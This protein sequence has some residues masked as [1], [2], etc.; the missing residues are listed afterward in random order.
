MAKELADAGLKVVA[1]ERGRMIDPQH[2]FA[3]PST[4]D[5]LKFDRHSDIFQDL[6]R[7]TLTFRNELEREGAADARD[8]LV[9]AGG[10]RGRHGA[11]LEHPRAPLPAVGLRDPQPHHRALRQ[12]HDPRKLHE[13]GLGRH[14]RRAGAVLRPVRA[15]LRRRRQGRQPA[16]RDPGGRQSV[17]GSALARVPEPAVAHDLRGDDVRQGLRGAGLQGPRESDCGADTGLHEPVQADAGPVH[18]RRLL[19]Q[20]RLLAGREGQSEHDRDTGAPQAR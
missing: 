3:A 11:S 17:R 15:P 4:Y 18:T 12:E 10:S 14:L 19:H 5:E 13:P 6:S 16:G 2:D 20:S 9:Q 7:E 1:L 8:G